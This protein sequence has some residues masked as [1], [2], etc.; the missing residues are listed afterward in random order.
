MTPDKRDLSEPE[1]AAAFTCLCG[2]FLHTKK[3]L[4]IQSITRSLKALFNAKSLW[5]LFMI[6]RTLIA[7][8][9][10]AADAEAGLLFTNLPFDWRIV[11]FTK[12]K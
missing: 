12:N 2:R 5:P 3:K 10:R 8:C 1:M 9:G 6:A 11:A 4:R 7:D